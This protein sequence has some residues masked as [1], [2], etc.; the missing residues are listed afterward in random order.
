MLFNPEDFEENFEDNEMSYYDQNGD[1]SWNRK[2]NS[3]TLFEAESHGV[4]FFKEEG[5]Y[6]PKKEK[7]GS[8]EECTNFSSDLGNARGGNIRSVRK[9]SDIFGFNAVRGFQFVGSN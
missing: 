4:V 5:E 3:Y 9:H 2:N 7:F 8:G 1:E 6:A